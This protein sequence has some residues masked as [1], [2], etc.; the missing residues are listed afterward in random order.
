MDSE[1]YFQ[2]TIGSC[3]EY[4]D[5]N[6]QKRKITAVITP[7]K[8]IEKNS[9]ITVKTNCNHFLSCHNKECTFTK[10]SFDKDE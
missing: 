7:F 5:I 6:G 8:V 10:C 2:S 4:V 1:L 9:V 3:T